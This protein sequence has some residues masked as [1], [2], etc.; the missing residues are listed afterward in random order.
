MIREYTTVNF[1]P[2]GVIEKFHYFEDLSKPKVERI[3]NQY[4][5]NSAVTKREVFFNK[6]VTST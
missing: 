5:F 1:L 2:N 3:G 4:F 6:K